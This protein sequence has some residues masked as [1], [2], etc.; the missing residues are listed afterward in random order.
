MLVAEEVARGA[1]QK[2]DFKDWTGEQHG[3]EWCRQIRAL[4]KIRDADVDCVPK[5]DG[6]G[7][8][9][10]A[11]NNNEP[12]QAGVSG[13][14]VIQ[15]V[16]YDSDDSLTGY[17]SPTPSSR[18][19]SPTPS[20]LAE[21]EKDPSLN[22]GRKKVARPVYLAQLGEMV[23]STS[24]LRSEQAD[25]EAQKIEVALNAAEDLIR[26]KRAFGTELGELWRL[27]QRTLGSDMF[28][29]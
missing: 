10:H 6:D 15:D 18:S 14:I 3:R 17:A 11:Q 23:R 19:A 7:A 21:I 26:R 5:D 13:K 12:E 4:I 22:M 27:L 29:R 24:G 16:G 28:C 20:E 2:L 1:G 25:A 9:T 8:R